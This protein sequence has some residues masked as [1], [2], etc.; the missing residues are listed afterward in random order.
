MERKRTRWL[1]EM[2]RRVG[3]FM[4][5]SGHRVERLMLG[6]LF[7]WFGLLKVFGQAS[8]GV[9]FAPTLVERDVV[10]TYSVNLLG[11]TEELRETFYAIT[12]KRR[13]S[14]PQVVA[15]C[16]GAKAQLSKL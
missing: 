6:T 5:R 4:E 2:D 16:N 7:V 12:M 9:F 8:R 11:R 10:E 13:L 15:V 3:R 14:N 1:R